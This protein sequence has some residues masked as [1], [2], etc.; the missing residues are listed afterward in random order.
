M[1]DPVRVLL[2]LRPAFEGHAGIPQEVRLLFRGLRQIPEVEVEGLIQ[3]GGRALSR[4]FASGEE[5]Q[6]D[7]K[8]DRLSRFV[9]STQKQVHSP[10]LAT[11]SAAARRILGHSESLCR[12]EPAHFADFTWRT[13]FSRTLHADDFESVTTAG[14]RVARVPWT[15]MHRWALL[16]RFLHRPLHLK[17]DT[18]GFDVMISETPYPG[19]V[20][21]GTRLVVRYH[22]ALPLLMPHTISEMAYHQASHYQALRC[23]VEAGALFACVSEATRR[24]L[25]AIFPQAESRSTVI[26]NMVSH[27]YF[28]EES[29]HELVPETL[30]TRVNY[31]LL[32]DLK[33]EV[34]KL[35]IASGT[36]AGAPLDYL[37]MV[38]TIE[39][40][41]NHVALV[42]AWERLR[43]T[44]PGLKLVLVGALGWEHG[45]IVRRLRPW[46]D[47]GELFV[48]EEVPAEELRRLYCHA[49]ATVCP[50]FG[51]GFDFAGVEAMRCGSPVVASNIP[52]HRE[53]YGEAAEYFN[54]YESEDLTRALLAVIGESAA[55]RRE[56]L[57]RNGAEVSSRYLAEAIL[58]QWGEYLRG[59]K[60]P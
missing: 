14:Y 22:D 29:P 51:E 7:R 6:R 58:P 40:R 36:A 45:L 30:R 56:A 18:T 44:R 60:T 2:E 19:V 26:H 39:P 13:F 27:H 25:V 8:L 17:L 54:P 16:T 46:I 10:Y 48:L 20:S 55:G 47:R 21:K 50:S 11:A 5:L 32:L 52:V 24:D 35:R 23:N 12:F 43:A 34:K 59:L 42:S 33:L 49:R 3:S 53:I 28:R 15:G 4:T 1:P 57:T 9:V 31:T 41:K 38:S 37:L